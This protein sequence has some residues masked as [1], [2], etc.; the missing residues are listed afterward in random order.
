MT[1]PKATIIGVTGMPGS[2]KSEFA[3]F[4]EELGYQT[5]VMG[6]VVRAK[7]VEEGFEPTP[8]MSRKY[9]IK[10]REDLGETAVAHL[11]CLTIENLKQQ[12]IH[13]III[14]GIRS[15]AEVT[16]FKNQLNNDFLI[17]AIHVDPRLRYDRLKLR[18]RKDAPQI[19]KDFQLR[20][21][22]E[23]KLGLGE[24]IAFSNYVIPNNNALES[25]R[26]QSLSLL[27]ELSKRV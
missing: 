10:L 4:A 8:E 2:G 27:N 25:F 13:K 17:V 16:Y 21:E 23:L 3:R 11:T 12:G 6:D 19:E 22:D 7:V 15:Q 18:G 24:T 26:E 1:K 14:D 20:D 9:M 5:V